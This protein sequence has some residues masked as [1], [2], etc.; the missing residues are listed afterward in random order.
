MGLL[1]AGELYLGQCVPALPE[2]RVGDKADGFAELRLYCGRG[3]NHQAHELLLDCLHLILRELVVALLILRG[4]EGKSALKLV[5]KATGCTHHI[6]VADEVLECE[7]GGKTGLERLSTGAHDAQERQRVFRLLGL[8]LEGV[9]GC[10]NT[11][12]SQTVPVPVPRCWGLLASGMAGLFCVCLGNQAPELT[13]AMVLR[14]QSGVK[15]L[16]KM[17]QCGSHDGQVSLGRG[18]DGNLGE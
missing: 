18:G 11:H 15:Q 10:I 14:I 12:V 2:I 16:C 4:E 5:R 3:R 7:R 17:V 9:L 1:D 6:V 13:F 8:L